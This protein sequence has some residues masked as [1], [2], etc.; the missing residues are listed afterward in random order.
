MILS[1]CLAVV[2]RLKEI[3]EESE[4]A[5]NNFKEEQRQMY[6]PFLGS[7]PDSG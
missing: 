2:D 7:K 3:M 1:L 4:N 5:I 6:A